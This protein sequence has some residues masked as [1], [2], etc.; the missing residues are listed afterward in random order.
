[1]G[2]RK[3]GIFLFLDVDEHW[4]M[5]VLKERKRFFSM[6]K[7]REKIKEESLVIRCRRNL[8]KQITKFYHSTHQ[9]SQWINTKVDFWLE[10]LWSSYMVTFVRSFEL[11]LTASKTLLLWTRDLHQTPK[12]DSD[13][14]FGRPKQSHN[15]FQE[16]I[17]SRSV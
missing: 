9:W 2:K 15:Y 11:F 7:F 4:L 12:P 6:K 3:N 13:V 14:Q 10:L 16:V 17:K 1:M 8:K 5:T